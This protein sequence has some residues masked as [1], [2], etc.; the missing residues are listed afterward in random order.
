MREGFT[1]A[2]DS[3][4]I[5]LRGHASVQG[6]S[7]IVRLMRSAELTRQLWRRRWFIVTQGRIDL[8]KSQTDTAAPVD[9][10]QLRGHV[11]AIA[12]R[13]EEIAVAHH[14]VLVPADFDGEQYALY[15]DDEVRCSRLGAR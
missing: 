11:K 2:N 6:G 9:T 13:P 3:G 7:S 8:Y 10:I 15:C 5:L 14:F 4:D 1:R 12:E